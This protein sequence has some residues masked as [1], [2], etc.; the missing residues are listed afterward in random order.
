M[1]LLWEAGVA[2]QMSMRTL[3]LKPGNEIIHQVDSCSASAQSVMNAGLNPVFRT[4]LQK[5]ICLIL[6]I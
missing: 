5:H 2:L 6:K 1:Q 4:F 3:D